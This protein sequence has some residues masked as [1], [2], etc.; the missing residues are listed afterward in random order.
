VKVVPPVDSSGEAP[1]VVSLSSSS[2]AAIGPKPPKKEK[3]REASGAMRRLRSKKEMRAIQRSKS[4]G[5][6]NK[7]KVNKKAKKLGGVIKR[8]LKDSKAKKNSKPTK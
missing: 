2:P 7:A 8:A 3:N 4:S 5:P 1:V 6:H